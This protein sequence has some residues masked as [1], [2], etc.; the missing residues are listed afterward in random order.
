MVVESGATL[1]EEA[2]RLMA[3]PVATQLE[4]GQVKAAR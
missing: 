2:V 1:P 3:V 4:A